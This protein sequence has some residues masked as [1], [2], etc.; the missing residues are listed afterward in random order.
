MTD[1]GRLRNYSP[2]LLAARWQVSTPTIKRL[3]DNGTLEHIRMG[4]P[5]QFRIREYR[6]RQDVVARFEGLEK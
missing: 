1:N 4:A 5:G 6:I 2:R 3:C